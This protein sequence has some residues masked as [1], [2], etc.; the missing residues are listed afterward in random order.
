MKRLRDAKNAVSEVFSR[1]S[2]FLLAVFTAA[3][4]MLINLLAVNYQLVLHPP[5]AKVIAE[6]V[7]GTYALLPA[8]SKIASGGVATLSGVFIAMLVYRLKHHRSKQKMY[9]AGSSGVLLSLLAPACASCGIGLA[10]LFGLT[11]IIG[12][13]P[14]Q[15]A[16]LSVIA[17][18]LIIIAI[19]SLSGKITTKVC[20]RPRRWK[21]TQ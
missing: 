11:G 3:I 14:F 19:V 17:G 7:K 2:F 10:A 1:P 18:I 9:A 12:S 20:E 8:H 13:L 6:L 21:K 15:G 5:S 4:I 16:E